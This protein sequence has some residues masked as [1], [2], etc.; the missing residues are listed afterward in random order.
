MTATHLYPL[1]RDNARRYGARDAYR[2]DDGGRWKGVSWTDFLARIDRAADALLAH[3]VAEEAPIVIF[4]ANSPEW[5]IIDFACQAVRAIPVPVHATSTPSVLRQIIDETGARVVFVGTPEL[6]GVLRQSGAAAETV[7]VIKGETEG[8]I[9]LDAFLRTADGRSFEDQRRAI[10]TR[11]S[12]EDI[13]TIIYTSGTTGI[14]RGAVLPQRCVLFQIE[15]HRTRLPNLGDT[16]ASFCLLPLSHVF[17]RTWTAAVFGWGMVNHYCEVTPEAVKLLATAQPTV[18]CV[19]PRVAE[20]IYDAVGQKIEAMP[21]PLQTMVRRLLAAAREANIMQSAGRT[22]GPWLRAQQALADRLV[23]RKVRDV[24]GGRLKHLV[25]GGAAL[26]LEIHRFFLTAGVFV[27]LGY[28]L[29][30]TTATV[31]S[32]ILGQSAPGA[33]GLAIPGVEMRIGDE[34]EIQVRGPNVMRGYYKRPDDDAKVFTDD[35]WFR[36]G[37]MGEIDAQG[38]LRVT[39]RLKDLIKTSNGKYVA[40]QALEALMTTSP[41]I[42]QAA[43]VGDGRRTIGALLVPDLRRLEDVA[44]R[45]GLSFSSHDE[46]VRL[47]EVVA[48]VKQTV[49]DLLRDQA[50]HEQVRLITLLT[51]PF[52]IATGE[53]TPTLK[54]R[55]KAIQERYEHLIAT[56]FGERTPVA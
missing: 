16:D 56:M 17:E 49:D 24:F 10:E 55:R 31:A 12:T 42:E 19:V 5:S 35:G 32:T 29:T 51:Q 22:P 27:N 13:W 43:V 52:A 38:T 11:M 34:G 41:L 45:F 44:R 15:S 14:V 25:V 26:N 4:A 20:K 2:F 47:P 30:E 48:H 7:V 53:L 28:G 9:A 33:V 23:L 1:L 46:L 50:K 18:L 39:D 21:G 8:A 54:L 3:G 37:D 40:P 36:T 6:A